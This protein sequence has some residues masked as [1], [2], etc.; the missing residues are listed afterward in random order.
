MKLRVGQM[1]GQIVEGMPWLGTF[2]S[3]GVKIL[4]RHAEMVGLKSNF[5]IL[6]VDDQIRVIKQLLEAEKLD[7]KRWP[8]RVFAMILD[9]WKNRGLTPDQVPAGE[10]A[11]FAN[12]KGKKL[13]RGLSGAAEDA[14]RRRLRRSSAGEHP[15][16]PLVAGN[17]PAVPAALQIHFG[18][19]ISGHQRG[20]VSVAAVCWRRRRQNPLP[21]FRDGAKRRTRNPAST[22]EPLDS[23]FA[24]SARP[25]MTETSKKTSAASAM[26]I[27]RSM[28]GAAPRSTTSCA[29]ITTSPAPRSFVWKGITAAPGIFWRR[30]RI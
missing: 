3:I 15:P 23:G 10:A 9:G 26:T 22:A 18:G 7:E 17:S 29:S 12:G 14:Q 24:P 28:A 4:R 5:T 11:S 8:A 19:R 16:V 1:V 6:D 25:G 20:A 21:S 2:H 30:P 13:Y 27:N